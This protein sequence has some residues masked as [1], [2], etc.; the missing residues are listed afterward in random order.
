M[1]I[2]KY[3][4]DGYFTGIDKDKY[5]KIRRL[6]KSEQLLPGDLADKTVA[7]W[8]E[9]EFLSSHPHHETVYGARF[10]LRISHHPL[11]PLLGIAQ[12]GKVPD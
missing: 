11:K 10:P 2:F 5:I 9:T 3:Y 6:L 1:I 4:L 12:S 7:T 8:T